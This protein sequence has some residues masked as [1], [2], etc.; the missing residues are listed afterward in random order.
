MDNKATHID[1]INSPDET[2]SGS[3]HTVILQKLEEINNRLMKIEAQILVPL[4]NNDADKIEA[5]RS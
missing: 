2:T 4:I 5:V 3:S 1:E